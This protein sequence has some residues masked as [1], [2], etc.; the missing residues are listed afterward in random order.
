MKH[1]NTRKLKMK[2]LKKDNYY[3]L[4]VNH[5]GRELFYEGKVT[6]LEKGEFGFK[7]PEES[8]PLQFSVEDVVE[9][10]EILKPSKEDKV[11]KIHSKKKFTDLKPSVEPKF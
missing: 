3:K 2:K 9:A 10:S 4:K 11:F 8:C 7:I 1:E 6:Y 5:F